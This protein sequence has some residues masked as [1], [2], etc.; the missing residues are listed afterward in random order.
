MTEDTASKPLCL[1]L[2]LGDAVCVSIRNLAVT[3]HALAEVDGPAGKEFLMESESLVSQFFAPSIR[4]PA[5]SPTVSIVIVSKDPE[6]LLES[7]LALLRS[8]SESTGTEYVV[9]WAASARASGDLKRRYPHIK[10]ISAPQSTSL[11]DL[12]IQ[13]IKAAIGDIVLLLQHDA[14]VDTTPAD[15]PASERQSDAKERSGSTKWDLVHGPGRDRPRLA[16]R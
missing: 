6:E 14:P 1:F 10:L 13:G 15:L 5:T 16:S 11:A 4:Q 7:R 8:R 3:R 12:R 9:T 2:A